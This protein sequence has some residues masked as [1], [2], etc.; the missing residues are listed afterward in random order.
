[1]RPGSKSRDEDRGGRHSPSR[2]STR[3]GGRSTGRLGWRIDARHDKGDD[4]RVISSSRRDI[5]MPVTSAKKSSP[6]HPAP[7][8]GV[9]DRL[10]HRRRR[11]EMLARA[12]RSAGFP[13]TQ[14]G[15]AATGRA[16][17]GADTGQRVR[18]PSIRS[19]RSFAIVQDPTQRLAVAGDHERLAGR[20]DPATT[21]L[22]VGERSASA[23]RRAAGEQGSMRR[24][25]CKPTRSGQTGVSR[26]HGAR[27]RRPGLPN[28]MTTT[29]P[30]LSYQRLPHGKHISA[31]GI[32][33]IASGPSSAASNL[34]PAELASFVVSERFAFTAAARRSQG[35]GRAGQVEGQ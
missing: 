29:R 1:M 26:V 24:G 15:V 10:Q 19:Y 2:L 31:S 4:F 7:S 20:V 18:I 14:A 3:E 23:L 16:Y 22:R 9:T 28:G 30:V 6:Q 35:G 33:M 17:V 11:D 32:T 13:T 34:L 5:R 25:R 21:A 8:Q 27:G 12:S